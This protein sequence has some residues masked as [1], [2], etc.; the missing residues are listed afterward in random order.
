MKLIH[1]TSVCAVALA[2]ISFAATPTIEMSGNYVEA[3]TADI[4]VGACFANSEVQLV[5]NLAVTGWQINKGTWRGV[6]LDGLN[7]VAAVHA[8]STLGD[9]T[10]APYPVKALL[11]VDE[12]ASLEQ[13]MALRQFAQHMTG[14]LL[15]DIVRTEAMPITFKVLGESIHERR[16]ELA[17]GTLASIR[18]RALESADGHCGHEVT[19]YEP[20]AKTEHAMAA[21]SLEHRFNGSPTEDL[22]A[23]WSSPDKS[24][25][26]VGTFHLA[27]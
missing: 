13:R 7:V 12:R 8:N 17:A 15:Q 23:R 26:F 24:S 21:F 2:A 22:R 14:D 11:I 19:W 3:R 10:G 5:G 4:Y 20:L 6:N 16:V 1:R 9:R 25:A 27:E 18:T